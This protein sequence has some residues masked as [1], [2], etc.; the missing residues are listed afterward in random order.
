MSETVVVVV[1]QPA[2]GDLKF[3]VPNEELALLFYEWLKRKGFQ[4]SI[5]NPLDCR[6]L[7]SMQ[8]ALLVDALTAQFADDMGAGRESDD[9]PQG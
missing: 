3:S 7:N 2:C 9:D 6:T 8:G 4:A 1:T 5:M